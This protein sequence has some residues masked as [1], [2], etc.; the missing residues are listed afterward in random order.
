MRAEQGAELQP[1]NTLAL[2]ARATT[3]VH[4]TSEQDV[5][6]AI[7]LAK[8]KDLPLIPLG[9]G[10]NVVLAGDLDAVVIRMALTGVSELSRNANSVLL[11][12]SAG[13]GWHDFVSWCLE[14]EFY[15]LENL[16]LIPGTVGAA[17]I[18]NIGAYGVELEQFVEA[19]SVIDLT[20][21]EA[22]V[23][24][25]KACEFGY[26]DSVFKR[27]L[28]DRVVIT[29]VDLRLSLQ[30]TLN[31]D[32]PS[33]LNYLNADG[34]TATPRSVFNA[35]VAIRQARLPDPAE[36]PNA[37]SF[38]KNPV[39]G[40]ASGAYL[41]TRYSRLP[42]FPQPD[43]RMKLSA[44]WMIEHCGWKG[45]ERDGVGVAA[46]HSLVLVNHGSD[47]G[48]VLLAL[49]NDI[50]DSVRNAFGYELEIEPRVIASQHG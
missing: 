26:R 10:S 50:R 33:L 36:H 45:L 13:E 39:V 46:N 16:A 20:S 3:L 35:V 19:V 9:G 27:E 30:P 5:R 38:F 22:R 21:A 15:G 41:R 18:Q 7:A 44:A 12:V 25:H 34:E 6:D 49:A 48:A 8:V 47:D 29:S 17:P 4:A 31:I 42:V 23:L 40:Q 2:S 37:G 32:Y 28:R 43:G 1:Y 11:R 24:T 14:H